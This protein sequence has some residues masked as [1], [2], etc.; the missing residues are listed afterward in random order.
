MM[1]AQDRAYA[2]CKALESNIQLK[3][4]D[5]TLTLNSEEKKDEVLNELLQRINY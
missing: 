5:I 2:I 4:L 1:I 3:V